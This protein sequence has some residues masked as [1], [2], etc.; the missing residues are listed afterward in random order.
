MEVSDGLALRPLAPSEF[1]EFRILS[2]CTGI[3]NIERGI[4]RAIPNVRVVGAV[5]RQAYCASVL[6]ARMEEETVVEGADR[7]YPIWDDLRT[8]NGW[9]WRSKVDCIAAGYPCQ[10]E[11]CAGDRK[12]TA[13]ERWLWDEVFRIVCEVGPKYLFLENVAAHLSGTFGRV[14]GDLSARG[15]RVEWDCIPAAAIGAPHLRDRVFVLATDS[16]RHPV[17]IESERDQRSRWAIRTPIGRDQELV[18]PSSTG[19]FADADDARESGGQAPHGDVSGP[20]DTASSADTSGSGLRTSWFPVRARQSD[21][22]WSPTSDADGDGCEIE[23]SERL[24]DR[25]RSERLLD[26]ERPSFWN[27]PDGRD[28]WPAQTSDTNCAR[29]EGPDDAWS[30]ALW[31]DEPGQG[32]SANTNGSGR[33]EIFGSIGQGG[34]AIVDGF[35]DPDPHDDQSQAA[36]QSTLARVGALADADL[37]RLQIEWSERGD[38]ERS[39]EAAQRS[40]SWWER[41]APPEPTFRRVDDGTAKGL[42]SC[43]HCAAERD[44]GSGTHCQRHE[45][46]LLDQAWADRIHALGN[47]VVEQAAEAAIYVLWPRLHEE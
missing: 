20:R 40:G 9:P 25:E 32:A 35:S 39:I 37:E 24:L 30:G 43:P 18:H 45:L 33:A 22:P 6:V 42:H 10:P 41:E 23:R 36:L 5:E 17:R 27:D 34:N 4:A 1:P 47:S 28:C 31:W 15:W 12:G 29:R 19:A 46:F 21:A 7:R 44:R 26:R 13:D 16:H 14:L 11:S 3:G 8:F 38:D 2:L